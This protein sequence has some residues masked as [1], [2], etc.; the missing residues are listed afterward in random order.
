MS[1]EKDLP[2][3][4]Q[5]NIIS[6]ETADKIALYYKAKKEKSPNRIFIAFGILGALLIGSGIILILAHNWDHL[7]TGIKTVLAFLPLLVAQG[8]GL[9]VI[10][11]KQNNT[12]WIESTGTF[13]YFAIA[14][15]ISLISQIYNIEGSMSGF[16][17]AWMLLALPVIYLLRSSLVSLL[18]IVGITAYVIVIS[19]HYGDDAGIYNYW[20]LLMA[21]LPFYYDLLKK[22]PDS[23]FTVFHNWVIATSL[24]I[25]LGTITD[26]ME[27]LM[28]AAYF[29]LF[30]VFYLLGSFDVFAQ[31]KI[32]AN[33]YLLIGGLGTVVLSIA[34]SFKWFWE[35]LKE[36]NTNFPEIM[37]SPEFAA[38]FILSIIAII[39]LYLRYKN[40]SL[41]EIS[42]LAIMFALF[43]ITYIIGMYSLFALILMNVFVLIIGIY[44]IREGA[45]ENHLGMLNFGLLTL[46]SLIVGRFFASDLSF[47]IRGSVFI[48]IGLGFF[49]ANYWMI[50]KRKQQ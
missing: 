22:K 15:A 12:A 10:L 38:L 34:L 41:K 7:S 17:L 18:Y 29:S 33:S 3:L 4:V 48:L 20:L 24:T 23:N 27:E 2:E 43:I 50:K 45:E 49:A 14:I 26:R 8:F 21:I 6:S 30:G 19:N 36:M 42:P 40:S 39:L 25:A 32:R 37:L 9:L 16:L 35:D 44:Y 31:K 5:A 28:F 11:K 1:I 13:W 46:T 47:V